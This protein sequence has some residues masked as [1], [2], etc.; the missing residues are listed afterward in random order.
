MK[1]T[2][3][4]VIAAAGVLMM[5]TGCGNRSGR[6]EDGS[7][8]LSIGYTTAANEDD[9]YHI[10][11]AK[12]KELV[13]E[14]S[15]GS[16]IVNEYPSSQLG[17]EP[18][19]WEG[20]Q[21]ETC[22]MAV[23]TNAYVSSYVHANGCL[24][25]PFIFRDLE[26]ARAVLDGE[27]G[28]ALI[29]N[30]EGTGVT[31]L[32]FS[33]G[34]FRQLCTRAA[35]IREPQDLKGLKIRCMETKTYLSAYRALGVNATPMAWGELL[36]ALQQGTVDGC[37]APLSVLYTNGFPD[38]C[39]YIDNVNL[40]YSPLPICISSLKMEKLTPEEQAIVRQ[41]AV[42]AAQAARANNDARAS[43]MEA[44]LSSKGMTI[45]ASDEVDSSAFRAAAQPCYDE[46][47]SYIGGNWFDRLMPLVQ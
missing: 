40:Y 12:F 8:T 7:I 38:I 13:E 45:V 35:A 19:M 46:M 26:Q 28:Q 47:K 14:R 2:M 22:D 25:L 6:N 36:T 18:E 27:F 42:E 44:D 24:D 43:E 33:G 5:M 11:A 31:C 30:M 34:G 15:G 20:M 39:K 3:A 21:T 17:S 16:V 9:P 37:D 1:K 23:M 41:A 29:Q 4:A 32:A 10:T